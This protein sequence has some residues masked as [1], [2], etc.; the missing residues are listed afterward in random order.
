MKKT[1]TGNPHNLSVQGAV[2]ASFFDLT[3]LKNLQ[4]D[5]PSF[6]FCKRVMRAV[7]PSPDSANST[8]ACTF[9][10]ME[11]GAKCPSSM[12]CFASSTE[13]S[14]SHVSSG[15]PKRSATF[16]TAVRMIRKSAFNCCAR[17]QLAKSLSITA[18]TPFKWFPRR[19][20]GIPPPPLAMTT[21]PA[22]KRSLCRFQ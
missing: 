19:I 5:K 10:S 20:T 6:A 13:M 22:S 12:Y 7:R 17:R 21:S 2:P 11:P 8:A 4:I 15:V 16:S 9:G 1:D 3:L 14:L 18:P